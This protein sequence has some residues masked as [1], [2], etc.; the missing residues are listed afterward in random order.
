MHRVLVDNGSSVDIL[1]YPTFQQM[2]IDK[3]RLISMNASH[4]SFGGTRVFPL[5]VVTLS[6][7]VGDYPQ[8]ITKDITFFVV[9]CSS[10]YNAEARV[11]RQPGASR[12]RR[13]I[14][15]HGETRLRFTY[16]SLQTQTILSSPHSDCPDRQ[17]FTASDEQP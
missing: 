7:M 11:L 2:R 9:D 8:Q 13:K 16:G 12:C 14:P 10:A 1:Y 3:E 15:T 17:A 5:G 4:V 6:V